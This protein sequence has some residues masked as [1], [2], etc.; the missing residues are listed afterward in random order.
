MKNPSRPNYLFVPPAIFATVLLGYYLTHGIFPGP[1]M[2]FLFLFVYAS[3]TGSG[4]RFLKTFSPFIISFLSYEALNRLIDSVP[5]YIHVHEP[6][7]ADL[8]MFKTLP[9]FVLQQYRM[10]ILD[11]MGTVFY[12]VHLIAPT[13]FAFALWRYR[14]EYYQRYA[15]AFAFCTYSALL[16]FL[17][18]PVAPPWYGVNATRVLFQ[19]DRRLGVPVFQTIYDYIGVNPF[20]AFPSLHSAY[21]WLIALF[22]FKAWKRRALPIFVFPAVIWFSAVYLGE[23]YVIDVIGGIVYATVAVIIACK[24]EN[25]FRG[26]FAFSDS[27]ASSILDSLEKAGLPLYQK[28][29]Q[30]YLF[31]FKRVML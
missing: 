14:P 22:A 1:E 27:I 3:Y 7:A 11:C 6:I 8:W 19:V 16:T 4:N 13:V 12:S 30:V 28:S 23:H 9:T 21:P 17:V 25:L 26:I 15:L 5:K 24:K 31:S 10:P 20:A 29:E 2:V 18:Y